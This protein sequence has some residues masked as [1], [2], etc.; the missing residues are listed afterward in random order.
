MITIPSVLKRNTE[1]IAI[2]LAIISSENRNCRYFQ[3]GSGLNRMCCQL[4]LATANHR[5]GQSKNKVWRFAK[6]VSSGK[7]LGCLLA[8]GLNLHT[9]INCGLFTQDGKVPLQNPGHCTISPAAG[10]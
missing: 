4:N 9:A 1:K 3:L 6:M 8:F 5:K 2:I 10:R 7:A